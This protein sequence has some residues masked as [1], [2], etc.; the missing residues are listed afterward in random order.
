MLEA[1]EIVQACNDF[2][3]NQTI[4]TITRLNTTKHEDKSL[5]SNELLDETHK[6]YK[7]IK[8]CKH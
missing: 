2:A 6:Y 8:E 7:Y 3:M 4:E 5:I 1:R